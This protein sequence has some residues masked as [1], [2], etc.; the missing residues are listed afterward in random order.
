MEQR[1][2]S[3]ALVGGKLPPEVWGEDEIKSEKTGE[4]IKVKSILNPHLVK[5]TFH[6]LPADGQ[7]RGDAAVANVHGAQALGV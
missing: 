4:S 1:M 2:I 6:G 5:W 7:G 3:N